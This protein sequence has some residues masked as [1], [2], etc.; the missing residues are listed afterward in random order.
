MLRFT[1]RVFGPVSIVKLAYNNGSLAVQLISE[2]DGEDIATLSINLPEY[3]HQ[4]SV[5]EFFVKTYSEN[6]EIAREAL[7]SGVVQDTGAR[8]Q[9][10]MG[11][12]SIWRCR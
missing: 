4:L 11:P 2:S 12:V 7:A 3:A 8:F 6:E 10:G 1:S 9:T 5:N